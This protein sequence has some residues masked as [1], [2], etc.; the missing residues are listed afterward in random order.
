MRLLCVLGEVVA[1]TCLCFHRY[2]SSSCRTDRPSRNVGRSLND[3]VGTVLELLLPMVESYAV[4]KD[5]SS[6]HFC[7]SC[8]HG[9]GSSTCEL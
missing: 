9:G 2:G 6:K 1:V 3:L 8:W 5:A 4:Q 7:S